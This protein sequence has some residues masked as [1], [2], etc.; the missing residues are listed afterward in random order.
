MTTTKELKLT[1]VKGQLGRW[2][3]SEGHTVAVG[4]GGPCGEQVTVMRDDEYVCIQR[5]ELRREC[6]VTFDDRYYPAM[7]ILLAAV[8]RFDAGARGNA[9]ADRLT[10]AFRRAN[11]VIPFGRGGLTALITADRPA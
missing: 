3:T 7:S 1:G 2:K 8:A 11:P 4:G 6:G 5:D 9:E 10:A